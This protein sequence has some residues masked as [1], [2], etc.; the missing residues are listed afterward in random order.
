MARCFG[1]GV[2]RKRQIVIEPKK[3]QSGLHLMTISNQAPD[4]GRTT[5]RACRLIR[6]LRG[7]WAQQLKLYWQNV[8]VTQVTEATLL[9]EDADDPA[10]ASCGR[11]SGNGVASQILADSAGPS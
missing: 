8:V 4:R 2:Y 3:C 6:R 7:Y 1:L 5:C 11:A 9:L 10:P